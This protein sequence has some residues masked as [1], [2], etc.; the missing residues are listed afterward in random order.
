MGTYILYTELKPD[1]LELRSSQ[2]LTY[3][4][5]A[6]ILEQVGDLIL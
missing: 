5:Q 3:L 2:E 1:L 6:S 4:V